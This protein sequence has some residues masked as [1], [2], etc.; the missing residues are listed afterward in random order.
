MIVSAILLAGGIGSRMQSDK[1][2]QYLELANKPL[3]LHSFDVLNTMPQVHEIIVVCEPEYRNL[4]KTTKPIKFA[5][6]GKRRQ[7]SVYNGFQQIAQNSNLVCIHDSARPFITKQIVENA[8]NTAMQHGAVAVGVPLKFTIK[9]T[10][11]N[12][13]VISTPDRS[14]FWEVQTPQVILP[15]LLRCG[16]AFAQEH[17]LTVTDDVSLVELIKHPLKMVEGSHHN[18]KIT[19]PDDL[20]FAEWLLRKYHGHV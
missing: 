16:F 10:E 12:Q 9:E 19:T 18:I 13:T 11:P 7:D 15:D 17:N 1:P 2:K 14:R 3:A 6:P 20:Q 8:L 4:F 5:L